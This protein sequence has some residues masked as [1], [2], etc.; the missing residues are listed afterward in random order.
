ML[1]YIVYSFT[2]DRQLAICKAADYF[3]GQE[4]SALT[5]NVT[6]LA[7]SST[8]ILSVIGLGLGLFGQRA[9]WVVAKRSLRHNEPKKFRAFGPKTLDEHPP[10]PVRQ[11]LPKT[12][13]S[14]C[15]RTW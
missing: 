12:R 3:S 5:A 8:A 4:I 11:S 9:A 2:N 13:F 15:P 1:C 7:A 14:R 6:S 10:P